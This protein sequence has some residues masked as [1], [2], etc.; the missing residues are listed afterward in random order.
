VTGRLLDY[1]FGPG[2]V[3]FLK[4][5]WSSS[6]PRQEHSFLTLLYIYTILNSVLKFLKF[7]L[8]N[9]LFC[10]SYL[11]QPFFTWPCL[12]NGIR[13]DPNLE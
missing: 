8:T 10:K 3:Y 6:D 12:M 7:F 11:L 9:T 2:I 4:L 5:Q 1:N 13:L